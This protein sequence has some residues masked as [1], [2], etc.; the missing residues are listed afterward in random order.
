MTAYSSVG[1]P[2]GR[3][4]GP[5]KVTGEASYTADILIPGTLWVKILTSPF[6]HARIVSIDTS[7]AERLEG[8]HAVITGNDLPDIRL[9]RHLQDMPLLA[10]DRVRFIGDR[11]AAVAAED[12][13]IAE[14]AVKLIDVEYEE[15][16]A[17]F[18]PLEAIKSGAPILHEDVNSYK[19]LPEPLPE[20]SNV[21]IR[22]NWSL[23]SVEQ[24]FAEADL[25]FEHTFTLSRH[26]QAYMEPHACLVHIDENGRVQVWAN[27]K[28]PFILRNQLAEA[29][30]LKP[31]Q[32]LINVTYIGGDFG[33]KGDPFDTTLCYFL[34]KATQ[35][36]VKLVRTYG[37]EFTGGEPRHSAV[38]TLRSGVKRDGTLVAR[39]AWLL[40]DS[41]AYGAF[42][43]SPTVDLP[44]APNV[45]GSYCIPHVRIDCEFVYTNTI[46]S[47]FMRGP[48]AVQANFAVESHM[49][50][51]AKELGLDPLEFRR[52]NLLKDGDF[53][54]E[55]GKGLIRVREGETIDAAAK[56]IKWDS[57][58]LRPYVGRGIA[59][60]DRQTTGAGGRSSVV[61][62]TDGTITVLTPVPDVGPGT[63]TVFGQIAAEE[64][65][66]PMES[67]RV[68]I[69][70]TDTGPFDLGVEGSWVTVA[71]GTAT[72]L[73]AREVREHL[74]SVAADILGSP[75][76][77]IR[78]R[79]GRFFAE[80]NGSQSLSQK[81]VAVAAAE[82]NEG[83]PIKS[84][85]SY[86]PELGRELRTFCA[87]A[88]EVEV[89]VETGQVTVLRLVTAHDVGTVLNPM[90][91]QGQI[92]GGII[93][94]LGY[95]LM[96]ELII[97]GGQVVT[98]HF[99][100]YKIPSI[101]D[102]PELTTVL[103]EEPYGP[104]PYQGKSIGEVSNVPVA[105]AIAN[106]LADAVGVRITD[107]PITAE[108]V[109]MALKAK[110][111]ASA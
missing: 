1:K 15:L 71:H 33:G 78:L 50:M 84:D 62:E 88:A 52:R 29:T 8:V 3:L 44:G 95:A 48:G 40:F 109:L 55:T 19:G 97:E 47:G 108:K 61:A 27:H 64:F 35:R 5:E 73:A 102:V 80:G 92:D 13:D 41:G 68:V 106:A 58:R 104:T 63:Q 111:K 39:Q 14:E 12:P 96:E 6:P 98:T 11:V 18:D 46:P 66:L 26:H 93:Q 43:P 65:S 53:K 10:R 85:K 103:L 99:G 101:K 89:D 20:P 86:T 23:G 100:D 72:L 9:G 90:T 57:P 45:E 36:P 75:K 24:A 59:V 28:S 54:A 76:E 79:N 70:D 49:D 38:I 67:V 4:E 87:Q 42:R 82:I 69:T 81:E 22:R 91:H 7:E 74:V 37:E 2:I 94:G 60:Y 105:P 83:N 31:E 110:G 17:V 51:I 34:A 30:E 56:A 107:L 25:T 21:V 77:H 32:I 16:P